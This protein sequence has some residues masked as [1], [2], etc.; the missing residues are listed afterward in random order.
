MTRSI[1]LQY[2]EKMN[3]PFLATLKRRR[4]AQQNCLHHCRVLDDLSMLA[5]A[6]GVCLPYVVAMGELN[7]GGPDPYRHCWLETKTVVVDL[8]HRERFFRRR[9]YYERMKIDTT[10]VR[11]YSAKKLAQMRLRYGY[12]KFWDFPT[13]RADAQERW[14]TFIEGINR[15]GR[16]VHR[17]GFQFDTRG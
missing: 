17:A 9:D 10:C 6:N 13:Q 1:Y 4:L 15:H 11:R 16:G 3:V 7:L 14:T 8:V 5:E 12:D 2:A